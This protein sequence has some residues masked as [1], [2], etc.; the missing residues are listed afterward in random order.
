MA[1]E[2]SG[3]SGG[4]RTIILFRLGSRAVFVHGFAKNERDNIRDDEFAAFKM[5]A[6]KMLGYDD[7]ALTAAIA[8]GI[9]V[10]V[11]G[12]EKAIS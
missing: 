8:A 6:L 11:I 5:L 4:F 3:K 7:E 2:G 9:L 10:E 12:D 1:R